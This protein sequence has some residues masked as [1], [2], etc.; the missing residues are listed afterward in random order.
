MHH[1]RAESLSWNWEPGIFLYGLERLSL[2]S[3][4]PEFRIQSREYL[5]RYHRHWERKGIPRVTWSDFC[6]PALSGFR[7]HHDLGSWVGWASVRDVIHYIDHAPRNP[8]GALDHL[9]SY[10]L[11]IFYPHSIWVD[12]LMMYAVLAAQWGRETGDTRLLD[13][14]A[15]QPLIFASVL[16]DATTG[17]FYHAWSYTRDRTLPSNA[18]LW[19]RGNG[20]VVVATAEILAMLPDTHPSK[21]EL[22]V[23]LSDLVDALSLWQLKSG[24]WDTVITLRGEGYEETSGS[25]LIAY[26]IALAVKNGDLPLGKL[27][28][29]EKAFRGVTRRLIPTADGLSMPGISWFTIPS[30]DL[31]YKLVPRGRDYGYGVGAYLLAASI[32]GLFN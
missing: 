17:L 12:S 13:F 28:I 4:D 27:G 20:W 8:L 26:G 9:G 7:L 21:P 19:L 24:L 23:L 22:R 1:H 18:G 15:E 14:A 2:A 6:V 5:I 25:A 30:Q 16:K 32:L 11:R 31:G 29:A 10:W 3:Q